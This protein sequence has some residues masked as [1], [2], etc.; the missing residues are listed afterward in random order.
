[1]KN[2]L[3]LLPFALSLAAHAN[4]HQPGTHAWHAWNGM[5]HIETEK[6][7]AR[8]AA[9]RAAAARP[10]PEPFTGAKPVITG[11]ADRYGAIV[12]EYRNIPPDEGIAPLTIHSSG[13]RHR[14][15]YATPQEAEAAAR[16]LCNSPH[17]EVA[18]I[19]ANGCNAVAA[20]WLKDRSGSRIYTARQVYFPT[21]YRLGFNHDNITAAVEAAIED[22]LQR[23]QRDPAVDPATCISDDFREQYNR[24]AL[25][26]IHSGH[27]ACGHG[28]N[29]SC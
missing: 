12:V 9:E 24:C 11:L 17:C 28:T 13:Q 2:L 22:A 18:A 23:C 5:A 29:T 25:P 1:M 16:D 10:K 6:M 4:P 3:L 20:G 14:A 8:V 7:N 19:Y 21:S 27:Q 26:H 15:D